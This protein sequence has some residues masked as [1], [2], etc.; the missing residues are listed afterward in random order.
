MRILKKAVLPIGFKAN[1]L[2]CGIKKTGAL[3]LALLY[4]E[5]PAASAH[6]F[7][8]NSFPAAPIL[9]SKQILKN[10][11]PLQA[12]L[13]NS[14][15]ANCLT[16]EEGK[17]DVWS[18]IQLAARLLGVPALSVVASSTGIIARRLPVEKIKK[19]LPLLVK[20]L[21]VDG[22][23]RAKRAIM[24]TDTIPKEISVQFKIGKGLVTICGIAKGSGMI[25]PK[26]ATM[27][28][29]ILTDA[30]IAPSK[31]KQALRLAVD[32]SFHC[33]TV[34]GCMST[35]DTV[36]IM[37]NGLS[38]NLEISGKKDFMLFLSGLRIVCLELAKMIVKDAEGAT[39]F[40]QICVQQAKSKDEARRVALA[41]ANSNLFKTAMF[42]S[43]PNV[44]GRIAA[45][46]GSVGIP[47][48]EKKLMIKYSPLREREINVTVGIGR[49][50]QKATIFTSDLSYKYVKINAE[51]N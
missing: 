15:N 8:T 46:V 33:I 47:L 39:K 48:N 5:V 44:L 2:A 27:L 1:G 30:R 29:F 17:G 3:D 22:I 51:Y 14:G 32:D 37:A 6:L 18:C 23:H 20:G 7:T 43:S 45:A 31:L 34:D 38:G 13:I 36:S 21:S 42:A 25:S 19:S 12:I 26:M 11:H 16:G 9:V 50:R 24:T 10:N 40:I 41:I 35:N 28:C 4:S 49:G